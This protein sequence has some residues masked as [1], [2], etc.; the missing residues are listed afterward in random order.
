MKGSST[1][2]Q[3]ICTGKG[4]YGNQTTTLAGSQIS[5]YAIP[6]TSANMSATMSATM[7][8]TMS[9]NMTATL[10]GTA[11]IPP[12]AQ[13]TN[14]AAPVAVGYGGAILAGLGAIALL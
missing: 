2:T 13:N 7:N 1:A 14:A 6:L 9:A 8:A 5:Y 4:P 3:A 12:A 10:T 11:S